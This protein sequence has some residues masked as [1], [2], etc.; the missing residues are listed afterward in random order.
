MPLCGFWWLRAILS[1]PELTADLR[2]LPSSSHGFSCVGVCSSLS[3]I[4]YFSLEFTVHP[5]SAGSHLKI[6]TWITSQR[7]L[8]YMRS[9]SELLSG[10]T[11]GRGTI[12]PPTGSPGGSD[13]KESAYDAGDP[14]SVP[15]S[16][17]IP[18]KRAWLPI[19]VF[20]ENSKDRG[21]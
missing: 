18:W 10:D 19:P 13:G 8:F 12:Q 7:P 6:L 17:K 20:L 16:R 2:S 5:N 21:A 14:S 11:F 9:H 15:G 4:G 1:S 3:L